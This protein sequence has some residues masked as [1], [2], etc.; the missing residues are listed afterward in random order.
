MSGRVTKRPIELVGVSRRNSMIRAGVAKA[1]DESV[2]KARRRRAHPF[3]GLAMDFSKAP[4]A[5]AVADAL[6]KRMD[7]DAG[8]TGEG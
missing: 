6:R 7:A 2:E 3:A 8:A 4:N 5:Q 1:V